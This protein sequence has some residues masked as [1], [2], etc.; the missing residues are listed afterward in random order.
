MLREIVLPE[1]KPEYEWILGHAVQKVSPKRPHAL[2]QGYLVSALRVWAAGRGE[3]GTE[4]RF[5]L[6]PPGEEIRPL[7]PDVAYL[8]YARMGDASDE[9]LEVPLMAPDVAVE[10][11]SP[12]DQRRYLDEKI[13]V[14]LACGCRLILIVDPRDHRLEA[15]DERERRS[16]DG[17]AVFTHAALPEFRLSLP[18]LFAVL[19]RPR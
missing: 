12:G 18:E 9:D 19:E 14:Y 13:R 1:T 7:V 4:W 3:V 17:E 11:L 10:V 16:L 2:L 8:S 5:R 15:I 6:G